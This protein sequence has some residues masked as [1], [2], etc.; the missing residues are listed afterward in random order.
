MKGLL[1]IEKK[2]DHI[3]RRKSQLESKSFKLAITQIKKKKQ[4]TCESDDQHKEQEKDKHENVKKDT[5]IRG[6]DS[7][8]I[9]I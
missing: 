2:Q 3:G 5:K 7:K 6:K 9:Q 1:Q 8:K 4:P